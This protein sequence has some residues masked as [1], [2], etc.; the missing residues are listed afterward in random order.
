MARH[1]GN[2]ADVDMHSTLLCSR[3]HISMKGE[4][5]A[6]LTLKASK[7]IWPPTYPLAL[8]VSRLPGSCRR[9]TQRLVTLLS[10]KHSALAC[11]VAGS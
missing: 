4:Q 11:D 10:S 5:S 1:A 3:L 6:G 2:K 7:Y 9:L 8:P